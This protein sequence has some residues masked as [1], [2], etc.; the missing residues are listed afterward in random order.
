MVKIRENK[1]LDIVKTKDLTFKCFD[2]KAS[3]SNLILSSSV[4][5][6]RSFLT[7]KEVLELGLLDTKGKGRSG[8]REVVLHS[9][10]PR[11]NEDDVDPVGNRSEKSLTSVSNK[12]LVSSDSCFISLNP[13]IL[14]IA[15]SPEVRPEKRWRRLRR[16][17]K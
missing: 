16:R 7:G 10:Y 11:P 13:R 17:R 8:L 14:S 3:D 9:G 1:F 4:G 15:W 5:S 2:F 6:S 12:D